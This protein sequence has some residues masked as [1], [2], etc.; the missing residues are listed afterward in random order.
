MVRSCLRSSRLT[1]VAQADASAIDSAI[2]AAVD[3]APAM[4]VLPSYARAD[5]YRGGGCPGGS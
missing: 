5:V 4:R 1:R 3:A 2:R